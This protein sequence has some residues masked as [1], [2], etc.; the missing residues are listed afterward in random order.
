MQLLTQ[1]N[2]QALDNVKLLEV[3][4]FSRQ[5]SPVIKVLCDRLEDA[6]SKSSID[7]ANCNQAVT[8]PVCHTTLS[9]TYNT[10]D[11]SF[12]VHLL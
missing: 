4:K 1:T 7:L 3:L 12:E 9:A 8:C 10:K 6:I 11:D 2:L 5:C